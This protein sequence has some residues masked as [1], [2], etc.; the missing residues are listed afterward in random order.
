MNTRSAVLKEA[1][2]IVNGR[3]E[4]EYGSP[5]DSFRAIADLWGAYLGRE[6]LPVDVAMMM[7]LLKVAR[8]RSAPGRCSRPT[9]SGLCSPRSPQAT[10]RAS[11]KSRS[12]TGRLSVGWMFSRSPRSIVIA[13]PVLRVALHTAS[14]CRRNRGHS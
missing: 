2:E 10:L 7:T 9:A 3:R 11:S 4:G 1:E 13:R 8:I 14:C 12:P 6:I 5:E